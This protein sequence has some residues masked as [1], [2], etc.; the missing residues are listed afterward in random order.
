MV[1]KT[2]EYQIQFL[3]W[4]AMAEKIYPLEMTNCV[5][6]LCVNNLQQSHYHGMSLGGAVVTFTAVTLGDI[7]AVTFTAVI[8]AAVTFTTVG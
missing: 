1:V 6:C 4:V 3:K 5:V 7:A 8:A 2:S